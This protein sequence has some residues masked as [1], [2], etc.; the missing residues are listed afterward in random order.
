MCEIRPKLTR[1]TPEG[2]QLDVVRASFNFAHISKTFL[3]RSLLI[4]GKW[5]SK[6][7][8]G[9]FLNVI[10]KMSDQCAKCIQ[11]LETAAKSRR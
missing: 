2:H 4:L 9:S 6:C 8:L 10:M 5:T 11:R 3:V 7:W 1:K